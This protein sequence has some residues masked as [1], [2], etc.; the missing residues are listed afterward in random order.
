MIDDIEIKHETCCDYGLDI[1]GIVYFSSRKYSK[2]NNFNK[3]WIDNY[4]LQNSQL[5]FPDSI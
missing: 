5:M 1:S 2:S 4:E 3:H